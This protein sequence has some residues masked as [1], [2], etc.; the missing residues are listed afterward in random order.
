M[1]PDFLTRLKLAKV[2]KS[3]STTIIKAH[4]CNVT[5]V[6]AKVLL[7]EARRRAAKYMAKKRDLLDKLR[8]VCSHS[9]TVLPTNDSVQQKNLSLQGHIF[10][11]N[12]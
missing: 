11:H 10:G 2:T 9:N 5:R 1:P 4:I 6:L 12:S 7:H 8:T 3:T